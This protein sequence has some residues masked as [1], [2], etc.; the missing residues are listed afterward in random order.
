MGSNRFSLH[1]GDKK[2][3]TNEYELCNVSLQ[4]PSVKEFVSEGEEAIPQISGPSEQAESSRRP[5]PQQGPKS[6]TDNTSIKAKFLSLVP[7][8][9][10]SLYS[11]SRSVS[12]VRSAFLSAAPGHEI[13]AGDSHSIEVD[14]SSAA[15]LESSDR[16]K[17]I[18]M[19]PDS[20]NALRDGLNE[21]LGLDGHGTWLQSNAKEVLVEEDG[22]NDDS[23]HDNYN[24]PSFSSESTSIHTLASIYRQSQI[25]DVE[26]RRTKL[27]KI[28][29][30]Y[31][32]A[33]G[34]IVSAFKHFS[35]RLAHGSNYDKSNNNNYEPLSLSHTAS[36]HPSLAASSIDYENYDDLAVGSSAAIDRSD[37]VFESASRKTS[38]VEDDFS[39]RYSLTDNNLGPMF[40]QHSY[41]PSY[42]DNDTTPL[43]GRNANSQLSLPPL[44]G[45]S[46]KLFGPKNKF[47]LFLFKLLQQVW[48]EPFLFLL[49]MFHVVLLSFR[50]S[51]NPFP[52]KGDGIWEE[53]QFLSW[54]ESWTDY[55][56]LSIFII[57]TLEMVAKMVVYGIWDDSQ[58]PMISSE[59]IGWKKFLPTTFVNIP[60]PDSTYT[61]GISQRKMSAPILL[62]SF[63][64]LLSKKQKYKNAPQVFRAYLRGSW[65]RVDFISVISFWVSFIVFDI[66]NEHKIFIVRML[67]SLKI[68]KLLN[69]TFGTASV[70][71]SVKKAI[72]LL[73][74]VA[75]FIGFFW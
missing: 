66:E 5:R 56:L 10:I 6:G 45:N 68:L 70:L 46:L 69:L 37:S 9:G 57:Y 75:V 3:N 52:S 8:D 29:T 26:E 32:S 60:K 30:M 67:S 42:D 51:R 64:M 14:P 38:R 12:P 27:H 49:I 1:S 20:L 53:V 47:R 71:R 11:R 40:S 43:R 63:T 61:R 15:N 39:D 33:S 34:Q 59:N 36:L 44:Y 24:D 16:L 17:N 74:N 19:D 21:A 7:S 25:D 13:I 35:N 48:V 41:A 54:G 31:G 28:D 50:L 55:G 65:H 58:T 73:A 72:P 22:F 2:N 18:E 23:Q 4:N 62:T